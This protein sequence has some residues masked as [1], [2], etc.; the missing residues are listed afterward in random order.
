MMARMDERQLRAQEE[1]LDFAALLQNILTTYDERLE[2]RGLSLVT[3]VP[4]SLLL[5]GNR[6]ALEQL[7]VVLLDNAMQYTNRGGRISIAL[8]SIRGKPV[9]RWKTRWMHYRIVNRMHCLSASIGGTRR[10]PKAAAD[11]AS[12]FPRRK[13]LYKCMVDTSTP[14]THS[15]TS[16]EFNANCPKALGVGG[17]GT[18]E[19]DL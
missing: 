9:W 4:P 14:V 17:D 15:R 18:R 10:T 8:Q 12:V 3:Q 6:E 5:R 19:T 2:A 7:L 11:A 13:A 1:Q 16:C